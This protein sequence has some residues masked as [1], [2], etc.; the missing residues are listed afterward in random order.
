MPQVVRSL[1]A[2]TRN[3]HPLL[4][5]LLAAT[6]GYT[7]PLYRVTDLG[8]E[9]QYDG[10]YI[11]MLDGIA[12][13]FRW[14]NAMGQIVRNTYSSPYE[15]HAFLQ[16]PAHSG[17]IGSTLPL[18]PLPNDLTTTLA[19]SVNNSGQIVGLTGNGGQYHSELW[20]P[21]APD[22]SDFTPIKLGSLAVG[23]GNSAAD[24][25]NDA[26]QV[27]GY[28]NTG[29][30]IHA[31]LWQPTANNR[32]DGTMIDLGT[33][34]SSLGSTQASDIN[35][36]GQIVG[37]AT[38]VTYEQSAFLW[39][40]ET[41]NGTKGT[42]RRLNSASAGS[43]V[44]AGI[45]DFGAVVGSEGIW[46]GDQ[47]PHAL[48]WDK[49]GQ[50]IDLNQ[51]LEPVSGNGWN[52]WSAFDINNAGQIV[53]KGDYDGS[54]RLFLLTPTPEPTGL[55][56]S[57]IGATCLLIYVTGTKSRSRLATFDAPKSS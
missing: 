23:G 22:S 36:G 32:A 46:S 41:P 51:S 13:G 6:H 50:P 42:M 26:G 5:L 9:N 43:S 21:A 55:L 1:V 34:G 35:A 33:L 47:R 54:Q 25:I 29:D 44:G 4:V 56:L 17:A 12:D 20:Q 28:A 38:S 49:Y 11:P 57:I 16:Q 19:A 18:P 10:G 27:V 40:P 39:S 48:L 37:I 2:A 45:N 30:Y 31:F 53:G 14:K 24:S 3:L 7:S 52:L 15:N 8:A